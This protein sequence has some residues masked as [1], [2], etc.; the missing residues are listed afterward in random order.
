MKFSTKTIHSKYLDKDFDV[1]CWEM[2]QGGRELLIV[3]HAAFEDIIFNQAEGVNYEFTPLDGVAA[4]PVIQCTMTDKSGRKIIA[5]GEAH[6][7][8]LVNKISRQN[9]VIMAGNRAFDRAAIRYLNL[10]GKVYSSEEI[11]DDGKENEDVNNGAFDEVLFDVAS[12]EAVEDVSEAAAFDYGSVVVNFGK[13]RGKN[14]TVAEI[15]EQDEGWRDHVRFKMNTDTC[16]EVTLK[17][18]NAIKE[19][20]KGKEQNG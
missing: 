3:E 11:P 20:M 15:C 5:L 14:M 16:G 12:E 18:V 7:E 8:S 9:P 10:D 6:P 2:S 4:H 17:Q 13:Y 1:S 19:Y